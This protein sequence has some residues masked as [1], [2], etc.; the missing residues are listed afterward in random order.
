[1]TIGQLLE[2]LFGKLWVTQGCFGDATAFDM[3]GPNLDYY[4][5]CLIKYGFHSSGNQVLY[6][7]FTGEQ[8]KSDIFIGPTYYSRLKHMVK[9]KINYRALGPKT[10]LTRQSVQGRANDGGLRIG[11]MERDSILAHGALMFLNDSFLKRG[12]EYFMAVCNH[13]GMVAIYNKS[14]NIFLSPYVDGPIKFNIV[15][16]EDRLEYISRFGRSFSILRIPYALKL[17]IYELQ[18]MNI[19]LRII[20]EENIDQIETMNFSNNVLKL[21]NKY[22]SSTDDLKTHIT[23]YVE[24]ISK[25]QGKYQNPFVRLENQNR[26]RWGGVKFSDNEI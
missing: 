20:T 4:G 9:D 1:M 8:I 16:G 23:N 10:S 7:G 18:T 12:D 22:E 19:Q 5:D 21:N 3:K 6:N 17:L 25:V 13:S 15:N 2:S 24:N 14:Q 26:I 11:E